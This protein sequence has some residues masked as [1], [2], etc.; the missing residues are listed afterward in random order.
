MFSM[1]LA[2]ETRCGSLIP[3]SQFSEGGD[4]KIRKAQGHSD[5]IQ[6]SK[7]VSVKNGLSPSWPGDVLRR[8]FFPL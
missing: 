3:Q 4:S 8:D 6:Q 7:R 1:L 5:Y 2:M